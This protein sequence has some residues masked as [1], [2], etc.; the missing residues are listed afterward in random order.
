MDIVEEMRS[1]EADHEPDGWPCVRMRQISAMC[2]EI[3]SLRR[4]VMHE[5]NNVAAEKA[6]KEFAEK[7]LAKALAE[8]RAA[9][10]ATCANRG[11]VYGLSQETH[12]EHCI[13]YQNVRRKDFYKAKASV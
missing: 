1:F 4:S 6:N 13:H 11:V 7:K 12:C 10:C 3:E 5:R 9:D 8:P 2:D